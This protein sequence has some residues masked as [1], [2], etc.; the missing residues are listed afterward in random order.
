MSVLVVN[1][2]WQRH[3]FT[4]QSSNQKQFAPIQQTAPNYLVVGDLRPTSAE[5]S[6]PPPKS[7]SGCGVAQVAVGVRGRSGSHISG[8]FLGSVP[9]LSLIANG[10][11]GPSCVQ[12]HRMIQFLRLPAM[13]VQVQKLALARSCLRK[14]PVK[15]MPG[16]PVTKKQGLVMPPELWQPGLYRKNTEG[17]CPGSLSSTTCF[18]LPPSP[19]KVLA[20][21]FVLL[22]GTGQHR[23]KIRHSPWEKK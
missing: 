14:S 10:R 21:S 9:L 17:L 8:I 23:L 11:R 2:P 6:W 13:S 12:P 19:C 3:G 7:N 18:R 16:K 15:A 1:R 4:T 5:A 20:K 22:N